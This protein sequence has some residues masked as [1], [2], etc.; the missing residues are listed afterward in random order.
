MTDWYDNVPAPTDA[1]GELVPLAFAEV[2]RF[3]TCNLI[4]AYVVS[5]FR[6]RMADCRLR[7]E[8]RGRM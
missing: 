3:P 8:E 5:E 1:N 7:N 6:T 2:D 4:S